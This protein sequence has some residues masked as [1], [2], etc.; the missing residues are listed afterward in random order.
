[1]TARV[2]PAE[3]RALQYGELRGAVRTTDPRFP[4]RDVR[5][6]LT[7]AGLLVFDERVGIVTTDAGR[8]VLRSVGAL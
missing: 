8:A 6:R 2:T 3:V 5:E 7:E 1:V 4:R